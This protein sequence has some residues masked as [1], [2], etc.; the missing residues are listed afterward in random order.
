MRRGTR[1]PRR[2]HSAGEGRPSPVAVLRGGPRRSDLDRSLAGEDR[3]FDGAEEVIDTDPDSRAGGPPGPDVDTAKLGPRAGATRKGRRKNRTIGIV[4]VHGI[5]SQLADETLIEWSSA[6]VRAISAWEDVNRDDL[7]GALGRSVEAA[8]AGSVRAALLDPVSKATMDFEGGT[9]SVVR[10]TIPGLLSRAGEQAGEPQTWLLTESWWSSRV[11]P[12]SFATMADWCGRQGIVARIVGAI[13]FREP[14]NPAKRA[15]IA[16]GLGLFLTAMTTVA[17]TVFGLLKAVAAIVPIDAVKD[18]AIFG[19]FETFLT[20]W[21]GDAYVLLREPVE[22]ANLRGR[23]AESIVALRKAGADAIAV[24]AHSGGAIVSYTTLSD[25]ALAYIAGKAI[26]ADLLITHGEAINLARNLTTTLRESAAMDSRTLSVARTWIPTADRTAPGRIRTA[27]WVDFWASRDPAPNG[28]LE[29]AGTPPSGAP[30]VI[31]NEVW[32]RMSVGE[33]HGTYWDNDEQFV[34]PVLR[35][36]DVVGT[37]AAPSR[38]ETY[39]GS[40][41]AG[42]A[43]WVRRHQQRVW[44]LAFWRRLTFIIP[45]SAILVALL[46]A[47]G[48]FDGVARIAGGIWSFLVP[49]GLQQGAADL[50]RSLEENPLKPIPLVVAMS[51]F[52]LALVGLA[53]H[54]ALQIGQ[55]DLAFGSHGRLAAIGEFLASFTPFVALALLFQGGIVTEFERRQPSC[56]LGPFTFS[57][58]GCVNPYLAGLLV[59]L[60]LAVLILTR[61]W[62]WLARSTAPAPAAARRGRAGLWLS[63]ALLV[64]A[65]IVLAFLADPQTR[66]WMIG[67]VVTMV[68][69]RRID[70][71][72]AGRW[73]RWDTNERE[74]ARR[75]DP[76]SPRRRRWKIE[77]A[78]ILAG[79]IAVAV[80]IA[81]APLPI[82]GISAMWF[83][84]GGL[85][86]LVLIALAVTLFDGA[87]SQGSGSAS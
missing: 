27:R 1:P 58:G 49:G 29:E 4:F 72:G 36:L 43:D 38:F 64:I 18:A 73:A 68:L 2:V 9:Q 31:S 77:G 12:P 16:L 39:A 51:A 30:R 35:E 46:R 75:L 11:K 13:V 83:I 5:G 33:D 63:V 82:L 41:G 34:L 26:Q 57:D 53:V 3:L 60:V 6:L 61:L 78:L 86:L 47:D 44:T 8:T 80:G 48:F 74:A 50:A 42:T 20:R 22:A 79:T 85:A 81:W 37:P 76:A 71:F 15:A 65:A 70:G 54:A 21:W 66:V 84:A 55:R 10:L 87:S 14:A 45:F 28:S 23:L 62:R 69:F 67:A 24:V 59:G 7:V 40:S 32:N 52:G 19:Q 25:P 17:L 56:S